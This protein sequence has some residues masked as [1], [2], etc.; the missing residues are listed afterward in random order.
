LFQ[1]ADQLLQ[2]VVENGYGRGLLGAALRQG[3]EEC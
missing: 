2:R 3:S 1:I